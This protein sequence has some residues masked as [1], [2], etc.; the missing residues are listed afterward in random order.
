MKLYSNGISESLPW[1]NDSVL[2]QHLEKSF[3]IH[4]WGMWK[5]VVRSHRLGLGIGEVASVLPGLFQ[6]ALST[7]IQ[8]GY[9]SQIGE[10]QLNILLNAIPENL[11][12]DIKF[13]FSF[14]HIS[15]DYFLLSTEEATSGPPLTADTGTPSFGLDLR[16]TP[17]CPALPGMPATASFCLVSRSI[18][19]PGICLLHPFHPPPPPSRN[20]I[21]SWQAEGQK[22][23]KAAVSISHAR[24]SPL[25]HSAKCQLTAL[26]P[27]SH[28]ASLPCP[29]CHLNLALTSASLPFLSSR[30]ILY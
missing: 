13:H 2:G 21:P 20:L 24:G 6:K 23:L 17:L 29:G 28:P 26:P 25:A 3:S 9:A 11:S 12:K 18:I 1:E 30:A 4:C 5:P 8:T 27:R 14:F 10:R 19:S 16:A 15:T 22:S 7:W